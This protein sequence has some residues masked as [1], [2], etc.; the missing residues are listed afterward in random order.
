MKLDIQDNQAVITAENHHETL[1]L[2]KFYGGY[3]KITTPSPIQLM[4]VRKTR[5]RERLKKCK[6]CNQ[7]FQRLGSHMRKV[8]PE[9]YFKNNVRNKTEEQTSE[10]QQPIL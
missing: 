3:K 6:E 1:E 9:Q 8:H 10:K 2:I 5:S 7:N 4:K